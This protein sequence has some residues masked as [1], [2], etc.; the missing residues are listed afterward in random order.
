MT[1]WRPAPSSASPDQSEV[2]FVAAG[3]NIHRSDHDPPHDPPHDP[4]S[5]RGPKLGRFLSTQVRASVYLLQECTYPQA[6]DLAAALGWGTAQNQAYWWDENQNVVLA[7]PAKWF[8]VE[9][10]QHSLWSTSDELGNANRRSVNLVLLQHR[11]TQARVWCGSSHLEPGDAAN[12]VLQAMA[13]IRVLPTPVV[14]GVDRNSFTTEAGQPLD[15]MASAALPDIT[16]H[17]GFVNRTGE[18]SY[19]GFATPIRDG[20]HIDGIHYRGVIARGGRLASTAGL[21]I[22]DHSAIVGKFTARR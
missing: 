22:T 15:L 1:S 11:A 6:S 9:V 12:R 19:H 7:D 21:G 10:R 13:L 18:R 5:D 17:P 14:L 16:A 20:K 8:D 4:W 3:L 2:G